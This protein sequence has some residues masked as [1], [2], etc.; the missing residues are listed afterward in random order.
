MILHGYAPRN[1]KKYIK[2]VKN[3]SVCIEFRP[4]PI[5]YTSKKRKL[6]RVPPRKPQDP[7]LP[8]PEAMQDN[9]GKLL[10]PHPVVDNDKWPK[11][12]MLD[13]LK[14]PTCSLCEFT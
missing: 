7:I 3:T 2:T 9:A 5:K 11:D 10:N 8:K 13:P 14:G 1:Q 4:E 12:N 6:V